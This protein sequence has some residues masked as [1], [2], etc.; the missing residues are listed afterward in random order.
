MMFHFCNTLT[1]EWT[2]NI[3]LGVPTFKKSINSTLKFTGGKPIWTMINELRSTKLIPLKL[4]GLFIRNVGL[5]TLK[6]ESLD[7]F[8]HNILETIQRLAFQGDL[9]FCNALTPEWTKNNELLY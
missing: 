3:V 4:R 1:P 9:H 8:D 7:G 2:N 5:Q 6:D